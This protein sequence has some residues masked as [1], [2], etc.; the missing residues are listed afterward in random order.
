MITEA[1]LIISTTT[2]ALG[3][4]PPLRVLATEDRDKIFSGG[5][6]IGIGRKG[7]SLSLRAP[8]TKP[9]TFSGGRVYLDM[10]LLSKLV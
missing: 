10:M 7:G 8:E 6:E 2:H 3:P 4:R 9:I 1:S 5:P